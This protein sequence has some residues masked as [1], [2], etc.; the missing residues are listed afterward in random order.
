MPGNLLLVTPL[1]PATHVTILANQTQRAVRAP[2]DKGSV[3]PTGDRRPGTAE[4][5][6]AHSPAAPATGPTA[7]LWGEGHG[8]A[9]DVPARA[10][11]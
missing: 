4:R 3:P 11:V 8:A 6:L 9:G 5:R 2:C 1:P 7:A 10:R